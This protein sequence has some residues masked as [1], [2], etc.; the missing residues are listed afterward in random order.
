M[1]ERK[2]L[3][4]K[5]ADYFVVLPGG[6]GTME[7]TF[8]V[9]T[10]NWLGIFKKPLGF[11]DFKGYYDD[12]FRFLENAQNKGFISKRAS[13]LWPRSTDPAELLDILQTTQLPR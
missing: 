4:G 7:E 10:S 2:R 9:L 12:L 8:E 13:V 1:A 6:I 11:L 5:M 3:M